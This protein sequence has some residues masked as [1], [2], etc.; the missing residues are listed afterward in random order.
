MMVDSYI[1]KERE[2]FE[3]LVVDDKIILVWMLREME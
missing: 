3:D 2:H 1:L